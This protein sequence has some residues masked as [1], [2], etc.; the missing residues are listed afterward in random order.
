MVAMGA[1]IGFRAAWSMLLGAVLAWGMLGPWALDLGWAKPGKPGAPWFGPM[2]SWMLWPGV[3]LMVSA[4][5]TSFAFSWRSVLQ[6][7]RGAGGGGAA[8]EQPED[9]TRRFFITLLLVAFVLA[10]ATQAILFPIGVV[11]A[12]GAVLFTFVLA[13]VAGRVSGET[14]ISP[15]G[16]MG[17][18]TQL[19]FGI[20][21]PA[22]P[23]ANLMAANVTGGAA[24]QCADLLHDLK[25]GLLIGASPRQQ[26]LSQLFGVLAGS[27]LGTAAYLVF[28]PD[29]RKMLLTEEW[30]APAVAAWKAVAEI[31][32]RGI[33]SMPQGAL[34]AMAVAAVLGVLLA[35]AE[36]ASSQRTRRFIP[37]PSALGI[38]VVIPAWYSV[39]VFL[40]GLGAVVL[41]RFAS[42]WSSRFLIVLASGVVAGESLAGVSIAVK[43][44]LTY[45]G[46]GS[47]LK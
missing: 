9:V 13:I 3:A 2:N 16:P 17:K 12:A 28:V 26:T 29:P 40:G 47:V 1:I 42:R 46:S 34:P 20:L 15:V 30:P 11:M 5:L 45:I 18:V 38:A 8:R 41:A 39:S 19:V 21:S 43:D 25:T 23:A 6:A 24:S 36:R 32:A 37:S 44:A 31:F 14:G 33:D 27:L 7:L 4:S 10:T 22:N 35:I